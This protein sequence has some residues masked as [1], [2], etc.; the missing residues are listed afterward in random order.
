MVNMMPTQAEGH[1]QVQNIIRRAQALILSVKLLGSDVTLAK[2]HLSDAKNSLSQNDY[3]AALQSA[4]HSLKEVMRLKK[5]QEAAKASGKP[6]GPPV[7]DAQAPVQGQIDIPVAQPAVKSTESVG[8]LSGSRQSAADVE[9]ASQPVEIGSEDEIPPPLPLDRASGEAA[10]GNLILGYE[11]ADG[12][13]YLI[14]ED[15]SNKC[16]YI[17]HELARKDYSGLCITRSNPKLI[18]NHY[19]LQDSEMLWLTDR[20]STIEPTIAPSLENMIYVAEE[21]IDNNEKPVLLLDGLEYL[22]SNNTFNSVLRFIR[23]LIDKI[24]ESEAIL[25]IGVSQ[26]AIKEQE[27]KLLEKE[28]TP[29]I[30]R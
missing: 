9:L 20:E 13:S 24:S 2:R 27:L 29:V 10:G 17:F 3:E 12:F 22:I 6:I 30:I 28:M 7:E 4:M 19:N 16:F 1:S 15:R 25:L 23:R 11:F 21:Y 26:L 8:D 5:E 14:E 18:K